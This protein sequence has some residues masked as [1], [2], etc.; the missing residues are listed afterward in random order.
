M[1]G[2]MQALIGG[3]ALFLSGV[4]C[5]SGGS[6]EAATFP[7]P[8]PPDDWRRYPYTLVPGD[9]EFIFPAEGYQG[10]STDTYYASGILEGEHTGRR[11]GFLTI[12]AKN[13]NVYDILSADIHVV[14]LFDLDT[15]VYATMSRFDLP[16]EY[17]TNKE[18]L[19]LTRGRL[20]VTYSWQH[21]RNRFS[22]RRNSA[23]RPLHSRMRF[24]CAAKTRMAPGWS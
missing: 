24:N 10:A 12:F 20:D 7:C 14:S 16:P 23:G 9:A 1:I 11:Y 6:V 19:D 22:T 2:R 18:S 21:G 17:R 4:I 5:G 3:F 13:R 8:D 15:H